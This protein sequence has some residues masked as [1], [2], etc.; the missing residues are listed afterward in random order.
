METDGATV[1]PPRTNLLLDATWSSPPA[2]RAL[3]VPLRSQGAGFRRLGRSGLDVSQIPFGNWL[4]HGSQLEEDAAVVCVHAAPGPGITT[5]DTADVYAGTAEWNRCSAAP[6]R[7]SAGRAWRS[8]RRCPGRPDA[9]PTTAGYPAS[10]SSRTATP[11]LRRLQTD[12]LDLY[13]SHRYDPTVDALAGHRGGAHLREGGALPDRLVPA[14]PGVLTG[15]YRPGEQPPAGSR[16]SHEGVGFNVQG[17]PA[18]DVLPRVQ[19]VRP[20]A[21]DLDLT[22][23]QLAHWPGCC[24]TPT[25]PPRSSATGRPEQVHDNVKAAGVRLDNDVMTRVDEVVRFGQR[26]HVSGSSTAVWPVWSLSRSSSCVHRAPMSV[27]S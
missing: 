24:R 9:G 1:G 4:T 16:A 7:A 10:T 25:S 11:L 22:M 5:F 17:L 23:A 21:D 15:K 13:Q 14:S 6:S 8:R 2:G 3:T 18:D 20:I 27:R 12:H 19:Q 26:S